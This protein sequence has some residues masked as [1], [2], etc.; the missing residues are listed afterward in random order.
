MVSTEVPRPRYPGSC[1][2]RSFAG[3][4]W[5]VAK[6]HEIE[7][8]EVSKDGSGGA[9]FRFPFEAKEDLEIFYR[10]KE[11]LNEIAIDAKR[12]RSPQQS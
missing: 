10:V 7:G 5:L 1:W 6:G 9:V 3:A 11:Q 8:A 4:C 2:T 12:R